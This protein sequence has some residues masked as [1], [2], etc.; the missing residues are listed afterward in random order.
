[1]AGKM[2]AAAMAIPVGGNSGPGS[3]GISN[4]SNSSSSSSASSGYGSATTTPTTPGGGGQYEAT[5]ATPMATIATV[6]PFYSEALTSLDAQHRYQQQQQQHQQ[7]QHQQQQQHHQ[8]QHHQQQQQQ[9]QQQQH[10]YQN[11]NYNLDAY[12]YSAYN[13]NAPRYEKLSTTSAKY[14]IGSSNSGSNSNSNALGSSSNLNSNVNSNKPQ[15]AATPFYAQ[16]PM[17]ASNSNPY[18]AAYKQY[19]QPSQLNSQQQQQQQYHQLGMMPHLN[20]AMKQQQQHQQQH[21]Q[22][23][24]LHVQ[25]PQ[26]YAQQQQQQLAHHSQQQQQQLQLQQQQLPPLE[27]SY[28]AI[29]PSSRYQNLAPTVYPAAAAAASTAATVGVGVGAGNVGASAYYDKYAMSLYPPNAPAPLSFGAP[30][31][32]YSPPDLTAESA[33]RKQ[34]SSGGRDASCHWN[35]D[36]QGAGGNTSLPY[37]AA[38]AAPNTSATAAAASNEL[39]YKY[40]G[41]NAYQAGYAAR[42]MWPNAAETAPPR[43]SCCTQ[44]FAQQSCYY[45]RSS[46]NGYNVA[47]GQYVGN[48]AGHKLKHASDLYAPYAGYVQQPTQTQTLPAGNQQR[49]VQQLN[50]GLGLGLGLEAN[51]ST[52]YYN[53]LGGNGNGGLDNLGGYAGQQSYAYRKRPA[54]YCLSQAQ[55]TQPPVDGYAG[56]ELHASTSHFAQ[57][58]A[59]TPPSANSSNI[60]DF[61][62]SWNDDEEEQPRPEAVAVVA[63]VVAAATSAFMYETLPPAA[64]AATAVIEPL[65]DIIIDHH[66]KAQVDDSFG[67]FDVEKELDE[68]RLKKCDEQQQPGESDA[69]AEILRDPPEETLPLPVLSVLP[70]PSPSPAPVAVPVPIPT[71]ELAAEPPA[72]IEFDAS[73]SNESTFAKEYETFIHKID[74]SDSDS[75]LP[76]PDDEHAKRFKFYKRKRK[77]TETKDEAVAKPSARSSRKLL[78]RRRRNR[79]KMLKILEF[80]SPKIKHRFYFRTLKL[81]RR[82]FA[83][84]DE[85]QQRRQRMQRQLALWKERRLPLIKRQSAMQ[86]VPSLKGLSA[87][88]INRETVIKSGFA[89]RE[90]LAET[91]KTPLELESGGDSNHTLQSLEFKGFDDVENMHLSPKAKL[92]DEDS[93]AKQAKQLEIQRW[94]RNSIEEQPQATIICLSSSSSSSS[95]SSA[96]SSSSST[97][98]SG[99]SSS[100]DQA[101]SSSSSSSSSSCSG[102]ESDFN[103]LAALQKELA[104]APKSTLEQREE[105]LEKVSNNDIAKLKQ[106][107]ES[108]G[109]E[110]KQ[111][112]QQ[113]L[114]ETNH[115]VPKL[116]DLSKIALNSSLKSSELVIRNGAS[117]SASETPPAQRELSVEEALAEM[118]QQIGVASDPEEEASTARKSLDEAAPAGGDVLLIN[119]AEIFDN[120]SSDLYVVQCDMNENILGVVEQQQPQQVEQADTLQLIELLAEPEAEFIHHEEVVEEP[121]AATSRSLERRKLLKYLHAKYV[122]SNIGRFYHAQRVLK[123]YKRPKRRAR[124]SGS[125]VQ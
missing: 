82:Q 92:R 35:V 51:V 85:R 109:D 121:A 9:Q 26:Q 1:A 115:Q 103:E 81:L 8:Q 23:Q 36:Y 125:R 12:N 117:S 58:A 32:L 7:H 21:Q 28:A 22:Q 111:Q 93:E 114:A 48:T 60:R 66:E 6:A 43:Q 15:A 55:A 34:A 17:Y 107:L 5:T 70:L 105:T 52:A 108:D 79:I 123:K 38:V 65:P 80:E 94:L 25:Q 110:E 40:P 20:M 3:I 41:S 54:S 73:N 19:K 63:P 49:Y 18:E 30:A 120:N 62:A 124:G 42:G 112:Q 57:P 83:Q 24:Q 64:P 37:A 86:F 44:P 27:P 78:A 74:G 31:P 56:Y 87:S 29:K 106:I 88:A 75:E 96:S 118:Y 72:S 39:Y 11:Y 71:P 76:P 14:N 67:S 69:L 46:S 104:V 101:S 33:Y 122:Q 113:L 68:L 97:S 4:G 98:S 77:T 91:P 116:S 45:P 100:A 53:D 99:D 84:A 89:V 47:L 50:M 102:E 61:L 10:F 95:S 16:P 90:S 13:Y 59:K 2:D 119:L